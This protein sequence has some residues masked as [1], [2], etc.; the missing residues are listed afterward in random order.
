MAKKK[1][2]L[3]KKYMN[4]AQFSERIYNIFLHGKSSS[5][6]SVC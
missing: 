1:K 5:S 6:S 2:V 4:S 3:E